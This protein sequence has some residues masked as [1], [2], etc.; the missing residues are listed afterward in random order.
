MVLRAAFSLSDLC[1]LYFSFIVHWDGKKY[2]MGETRA[3]DPRTLL[4]FSAPV[5]AVSVALR[6]SHH[7]CVWLFHAADFNTASAWKCPCTMLSPWQYGHGDIECTF[8]TAFLSLVL[9]CWRC[10]G[11]G[12]CYND[13]R[14]SLTPL[15]F[16]GVRI[17]GAARSYGA[18][19]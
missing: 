16:N 7:A 11:C 1:K 2:F 6:G 15:H 18:Q 17:R 4:L 19:Y 14:M 10:I 8:P 3:S 5:H 12:L 13:V 9:S